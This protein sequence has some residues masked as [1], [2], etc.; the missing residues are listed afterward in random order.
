M[1]RHREELDLLASTADAERLSEEQLL[2]WTRAL[3]SL[4][5][6]LGTFLDVQEGD[7][8][9]R[10]GQRRGV[11]LPVAHLPAGRGH[12]GPRRRT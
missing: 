10:P 4:R 8:G 5:L 2:A 1:A 7:E 9:R 12:R 11:A 6:V 3:N